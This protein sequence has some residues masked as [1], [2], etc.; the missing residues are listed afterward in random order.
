MKRFWMF[1]L[2]LGL[3]I[4]T[5]AFYRPTPAV[6]AAPGPSATGLC[7]VLDSTCAAID[8]GFTPTSVKVSV[9]GSVTS[10]T[11]S[12]TTTST[13]TSAVKCD[14]ETLG[15]T[16]GETAP[17]QPCVITLGGTSTSIDDWKETISKSGK[18]K[19]TCKS[20]GTDTK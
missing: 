12:G 4:G 8:N 17:T 5:L 19:L 3:I 11:C 1:S 13:V 7:T 9:S 16:S 18:V 14:G 10:V 6:A 20:G 2:G 15:G